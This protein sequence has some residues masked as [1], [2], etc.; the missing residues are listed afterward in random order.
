[1]RENCRG[2]A[3][4]GDGVGDGSGRAGAA[5]VASAVVVGEGESD[6]EAEAEAKPDDGA[7]PGAPGVQAANTVSPAPAA[8]KRAKLRRLVAV[9][10]R[11]E[12]LAQS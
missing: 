3:E 4:E 2:S 1:M 12:G 9:S 10:A 5:V 8:R 11:P 7:A 6:G